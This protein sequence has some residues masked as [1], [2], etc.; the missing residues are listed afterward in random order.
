M[1]LS[2]SLGAVLLAL[3]H[4]IS[5]QKERRERYNM[6]NVVIKGDVYTPSTILCISESPTD[7]RLSF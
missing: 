3:S 5:Q 4:W 6:K 7:F 2:H 1:L